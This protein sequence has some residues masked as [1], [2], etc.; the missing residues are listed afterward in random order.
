VCDIE[1]ITLVNEDEGLDPLGGYRAKRKKKEYNCIP[2][3]RHI[4]RV[5]G[6]AIIL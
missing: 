3:T 4:S 1:K 2:A 5:Y 6:V